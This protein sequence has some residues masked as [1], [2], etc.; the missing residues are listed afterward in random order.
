MYVK[1][2]SD[3]H[4]LALDSRDMHRAQY[5]HLYLYLLRQQNY[6]YLYSKQS[7][8]ALKSCFRFYYAFNF[9]K[10]KCYSK[11]SLINYLMKGVITLGL[12]LEIID[13]CADY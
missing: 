4:K 8:K 6:L 3:V 10:L 11:C 7:G 5:L 9:R 2:M 12:E 13:D 1:L